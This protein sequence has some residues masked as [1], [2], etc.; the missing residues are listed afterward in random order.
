MPEPCRLPLAEIEILKDVF[1]PRSSGEWQSESHVRTLAVDLKNSGDSNEKRLETVLVFWVGDAWALLDGHHRIAAI[2]GYLG[3]KAR[4]TIAVEVF[5]GTLEAA[6]LEAT[7]RNS[8]NKLPMTSTDKPEQAWKHLLAGDGSH[9]EIALACGVSTKT[10]QRM[11]AVVR[12]HGATAEGV[13]VLGGLRWWQARMLVSGVAVPHPKE[14]FKRDDKVRRHGEA[15]AKVIKDND[16]AMV[17][18][19]LIGLAP[20]PRTV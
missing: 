14:N 15:L 10:V 19:G 13:E 11:Q 7:R 20:F 6:K 18:D 5:S 8:R 9:R 2:S 17:G 3:G 12:L 4:R 16:P 1:Q